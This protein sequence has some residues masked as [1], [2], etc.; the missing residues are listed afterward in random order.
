MSGINN[1][2][3]LNLTTVA[4]LLQY[5]GS[6]VEHRDGFSS[7]KQFAVK[8]KM[9]NLVWISGFDKNMGVLVKTVRVGCVQIEIKMKKNKKTKSLKHQAI[10]FKILRQI[11]G[12]R[13]LFL[14]LGRMTYSH[15]PNWIFI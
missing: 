4:K 15:F 8:S 13:V 12:S 5:S 9:V 1:I 2:Y 14:A 11:S 3:I 10:G 7:D 6:R